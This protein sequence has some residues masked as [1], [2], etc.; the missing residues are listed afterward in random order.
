MLVYAIALIETSLIVMSSLYMVYYYAMK[1]ISIF[2]KLIVSLSWM[3]GMFIIITIPFD[4][5]SKV[6]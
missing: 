2:I 5:Y 1:R 3:L 6:N 4:I